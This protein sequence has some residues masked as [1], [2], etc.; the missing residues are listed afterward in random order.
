M[1][2]PIVYARHASRRWESM[3]MVYTALLL[4]EAVACPPHVREYIAGKLGLGYWV[5]IVVF[6]AAANACFCLGPVVELYIAAFLRKGIG[7]L[8]YPLFAVGLY[9]STFVVNPCVILPWSER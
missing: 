2:N 6:V 4:L 8:R 9:I 7:G 1:D 5:T 3:R